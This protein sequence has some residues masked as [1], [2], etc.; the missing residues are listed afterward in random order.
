MLMINSFITKEEQSIYG[1]KYKIS[2][3]DDGLLNV[4]FTNPDDLSYNQ[5]VLF[6]IIEDKISEFF[7]YVG[8]EWNRDDFN[9]AKSKLVYYMDGR[10]LKKKSR[11]PVYLNN[12]DKDNIKRL[13]KTINVFEWSEGSESFYSPVE[14]SDIK[15][16]IE[17]EDTVAINFKAML[18]NPEYTDDEGDKHDNMSLQFLGEVFNVLYDNDNFY[19]YVRDSFADK[20]IDFLWNNPLMVDT[21][22][23][24]LTAEPTFYT[25]EGMIKSW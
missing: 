3:D 18:L 12:D 25:K 6:G 16:V 2:L 14:L 19:E 11:I 20:I 13:A 1:I 5:E 10:Y 21:N 4:N 9:D 22:Y 24:L 23:M 17:S 8:S 7:K 15:V